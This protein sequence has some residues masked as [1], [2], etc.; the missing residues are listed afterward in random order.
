M[1]GKNTIGRFA[2]TPAREGRPA[3]TR[4]YPQRDL[5]EFNAAILAE[6]GK[7]ADTPIRLMLA[8]W[9]VTPTGWKN[10]RNGRTRP[11][12]YPMTT[13]P[14]TPPVVARLLA[15]RTDDDRSCFIGDSGQPGATALYRDGWLVV[16]HFAGNAVATAEEIA[17][18]TL[19]ETADPEALNA[20]A[21]ATDFEGEPLWLIDVRAFDELGGYGRALKV[22]W[23][24][25]RTGE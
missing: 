12:G 25:D 14:K 5:A 18:V 3:V 9:S 1:T 10:D 16:Q 6:L 7:P 24:S 4:Y 21:M 20:A 8:E 11:G 19:D 13:I 23:R 22:L 2:I 15:C 17:L